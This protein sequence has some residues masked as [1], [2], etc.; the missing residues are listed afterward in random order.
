MSK[1]EL[2]IV[3]STNLKQKQRSKS[4]YG[5][6]DEYNSLSNMEK[7]LIDS[8]FLTG[9]GEIRDITDSEWWECWKQLARETLL[10]EIVRYSSTDD[11]ISDEE[12]KE[13][14]NRISRASSSS[15]ATYFAGY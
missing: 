10:E 14:L 1:H 5:T 11:P 2:N 13:Y 9:H 7:F 3:A 4:F 12:Q 6:I 8:K 15:G